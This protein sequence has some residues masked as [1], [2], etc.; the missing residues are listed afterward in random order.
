EHRVPERGREGDRAARHLTPVLAHEEQEPA[1]VSRGGIDR[2]VAERD[3]DREGVVGPLGF[4]ADEL[5]LAGQEREIG[6]E[7]RGGEALTG[8]RSS[9]FPGNG[10]DG[11][12]G[13][14]QKR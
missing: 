2:R 10:G 4:R 5:P 12:G 1:V 14:G 11:Q 8:T 13:L 3:T 7:T 9:L 6:T